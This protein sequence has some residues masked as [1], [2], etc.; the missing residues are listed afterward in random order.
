MVNPSGA[1]DGAN[2]PNT[3]EWIEFYNASASPVNIGCWFFTDGDFAVT[4]PAGTTIPAGGY[5]TVASASGSGLSPNL[6]WATCGCTSGPTTEVGI[7]TNSAEQIILYNAT[8]TIIDAIIWSTGQLPDGMTTSVVGSC[9][10]QSVT[11]P[12]NGATYESIG[13]QTDGASKERSVDGGSTWQNA[14]SPTFGSTNAIILPIELLEFKATLKNKIVE[15]NWTTLTELNNDFF[16]IERSA[17][18]IL[19]KSIHVL[20]G[21][22]NS[23]SVINYST[24]DEEP[25]NGTSYYRL[26]Q[27]DFNGSYSYS[28][29]ESVYLKESNQIEVYP[30]PNETGL[31]KIET[32]NT[33]P[34]DIKLINTLGQIIY[35]TKSNNTITEID[36]T[37]FEKGVYIVYINN[38]SVNFT[39]KVIYN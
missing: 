1:N 22:G 23:L 13:S 16:T 37:A 28:N 27:T 38:E 4:F 15:I 17:D 34:F 31:L 30:N 29:I 6:N 36:L 19:F 5:Y 11:F 3:A 20:N 2:M 39:R 33:N 9:A 7:F 35:H 8:G 32:D 18:G 12:A 21:A 24:I 26:K 14:T 25:F 10:S